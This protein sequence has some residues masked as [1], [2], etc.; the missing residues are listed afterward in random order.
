MVSGQTVQNKEN[1]NINMFEHGEFGKGFLFHLKDES[2]GYSTK[3]KKLCFFE[4]FL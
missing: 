4:Q 2:G 1:E 3:E